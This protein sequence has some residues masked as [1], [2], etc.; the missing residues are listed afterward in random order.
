MPLSRVAEYA[1][2]HRGPGAVP[3]SAGETASLIL[4]P[5]G[6]FDSGLPGNRQRPSQQ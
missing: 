6:R 3:L 1:A 5:E 2:S 4:T